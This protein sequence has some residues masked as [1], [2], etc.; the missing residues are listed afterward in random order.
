[1][2]SNTTATSGAH[3]ASVTFLAIRA[4]RKRL[5][6]KR[7]QLDTI[8]NGTGSLPSKKGIVITS[9]HRKFV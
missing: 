8:E 2:P 9:V 3:R 4:V 1:V 7:S 6:G 5:A